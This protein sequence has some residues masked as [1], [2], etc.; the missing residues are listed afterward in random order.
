MLTIGNKVK[1]IN[2]NYMVELVETYTKNNQGIIKDISLVDGSFTVDFGKNIA[3]KDE[4]FIIYKVFSSQLEK[5]PADE[6]I[7]EIDLDNKCYM[8]FNKSQSLIEVQPI[9]KLE[10]NIFLSLLH[11]YSKEDGLKIKDKKVVTI[12]HNGTGLCIFKFMNT[13]KNIKLFITTIFGKMY[14][15]FKEI[16]AYTKIED[17]EEENRLKLKLTT[18]NT[19]YVKNNTIA[20]KG[21]SVVVDLNLLNKALEE[22]PMRI[23][24]ENMRLF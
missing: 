19:K 6:N 1:L 15:Y 8:H 24:Q 11:E 14:N 18:L 10:H 16:D 2:D 17:E 12:N 21:Y 20:Y 23:N 13:K 9:V 5:L 4:N 3:K 22:E 7:Q